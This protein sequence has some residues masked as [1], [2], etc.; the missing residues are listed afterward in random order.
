[1]DARVPLGCFV[2]ITEVALTFGL[3]F[4]AKCYALIFSNKKM[5]WATFWPI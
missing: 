2:K 4:H 1:M 3:F 5:G